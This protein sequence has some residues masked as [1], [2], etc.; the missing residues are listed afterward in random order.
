MKLKINIFVK[1]IFVFFYL[2]VLACEIYGLHSLFA[3]LNKQ[4]N[5]LEI[6]SSNE[7]TIYTFWSENSH[8]GCRIDIL[9]SYEITEKYP[10]LKHNL[11][12]VM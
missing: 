12:K 8:V 3:L 11:Y 9:K 1:Y 7:I 10:Y 5:T 6:L 4:T 2:R